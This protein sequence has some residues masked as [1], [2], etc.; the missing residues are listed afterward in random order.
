MVLPMK[1]GSD[2]HAR[3]LVQ[4]KMDL[5]VPSG[6]L[7]G[8][9]ELVKRLAASHPRVVLVEAPAGWGKTS[10]L[11]SLMNTPGSSEAFAFVRLGRGDNDAGTFW[12]YVVA[13]LRRIDPS[14]APDADEGLQLSGIDPT[15]SVVPS[16]VNSL[17]E[18]QQPVSLVLDDYHLITDADVHRSVDFLLENAPSNLT[19][20]LSTRFDPPLQLQQYRVGGELVEVRSGDLRLDAAGAQKMFADRFGLELDIDVAQTLCD[21]TEGWPAGVQLAALSCASDRDPATFIASFSGTDRNVVDYLTS[22][23]L[24]RVSD[25]TRA[26]LLRTSILDEFSAGLCDA[27][28]GS[29]DSAIMLEKLEQDAMFLV[30][31]DSERQWFRY[32]HLF[33]DWLRHTLN[34]TAA[35]EVPELHR[36]AS[37][38]HTGR[39]SDRSRDRRR[40]H[41][42][43]SAAD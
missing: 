20:I 30:P 24:S 37:L 2:E 10:L 31:L 21:K 38:W 12:S 1:P 23:V 26:F 17:R 28:V 19:V 42:R 32:H 13:S 40:R 27:V 35:Q 6:A 22:E 8:H 18:L 41:R 43:R 15:R 11:A 5:P 16:V 33:G 25:Q 34:R 14:L 7:I 9:P 39:P 29:N 3:P 36:R 4:T